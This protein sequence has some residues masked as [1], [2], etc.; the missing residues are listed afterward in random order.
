MSVLVLRSATAKMLPPR[1]P[2]PP[3][4]P[5]LGMNF[6]RRKLA[7]ALPPL[8][9]MTSMVA[10]STNFI[11]L[12]EAKKPCRMRQGF[13]RVVNGRPLLGRNHRHDLLVQRALEA[14]LNLAVDQRE[15]GVVLADA[16]VGAGMEASAALAHD[17]RASRDLLAAKNL[18]AQSFRF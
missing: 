10:S 9:A 1:P 15:Q 3:S 18:D 7:T 6:S 14:E 2:S 13:C 16:D 4:G 11:C 17:D 5:P 12:P 8:P